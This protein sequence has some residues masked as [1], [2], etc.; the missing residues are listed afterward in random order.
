EDD[1]RILGRQRLEI[2]R[3]GDEMRQ[4]RRDLG[5]RAAARGEESHQLDL[6]MLGQDGGELRAGVA[7]GADD[8]DAG[9]HRALLCAAEMPAICCRCRAKAAAAF[10]VRRAT[11]MVSSPPTVPRTSS[12]A[13]AS[14]ALASG[15]APAG[16][17]LITTR[18]T[19][20]SAERTLSRT[21][22]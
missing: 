7:G 6:G 3:L 4:R 9:G 2:E 22:C 13:A 12:R 18:F 8:G 17:V 1:L 5:T 19:A 10:A 11:K 15:C 20:A 21:S 16:G 14:M